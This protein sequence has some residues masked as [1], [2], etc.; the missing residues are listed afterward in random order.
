[1]SQEMPEHLKFIAEATSTVVDRAF[2]DQ[3]RVKFSGPPKQESKNIIEYEKRMQVTGMEKFNAPCYVAGAS[4][5]KSEEDQKQAK[6][7]GGLVI[8]A[9]Q[10]LF[11]RILKA[12]GYSDVDEDDEE[13]LAHK[14]AEAVEKFASQLVSTLSAQG[15]PALKFE[16]SQ[17]FRNTILGGIPI[18]FQEHE[19]AELSYSV[20]D[21]VKFVVEI[22]MSPL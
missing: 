15:K 5:Y 1:M 19:K 13:Y 11:P 4:F 17:G 10:Q 16:V 2:A 18:D 21:V 8:Y 20:D 12:L 14:C 22:T 7:C 6:A 3:L 9:E